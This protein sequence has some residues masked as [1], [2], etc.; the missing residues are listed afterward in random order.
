MESILNCVSEWM[1][2][3]F[4]DEKILLTASCTAALEMSVILLDVGSGNEIIMQFFTFVTTENAF[5]LR[6]AKI[7]FVD[8][9]QDTMNIDEKIEK[10][11]TKRT[12]TIVVVHYAGVLYE[13]DQIIQLALPKATIYQ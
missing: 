5:A 6:G 3:R 4:Q 7:M 8:I 9:R 10:A 11:I 1:E 2:D 12:K 13:M